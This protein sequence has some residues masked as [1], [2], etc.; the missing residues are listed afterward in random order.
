MNYSSMKSIV[1]SFILFLS[2]LT[3]A[4][5]QQLTPTSTAEECV[6]FIDNLIK[7]GDGRDEKYNYVQ[8]SSFT[9]GTLVVQQD[10]KYSKNYDIRSNIN[11]ANF[12]K[13]STSDSSLFVYIIFN[14][15]N[16]TEEEIRV[17]IKTGLIDLDMYKNELGGV[18][19]FKI[20]LSE[21][22]K[23]KDL[24]LAANRLKKIVEEKGNIFPASGSPSIKIPHIEGKPSYQETVEYINEFLE[25]GNK[26][27]LFCNT[28]RFNRR[29]AS[30][31]MNSRGATLLLSNY[32]WQGR[33]TMGSPTKTEKFRINISEVEDIRIVTGEGF[34][35]GCLQVGLWFVEKGKSAT[36]VMHLPLW[37]TAFDT[38]NSSEFKESQIYRAFNHIRQLTGA[39]EPLKFD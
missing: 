25:D 33:A 11:W 10:W 6:R 38:Y 12:K 21:K 2:C 24:E 39:P 35:G 27:D 34:A 32:S 16:I 14:D 26:N 18:L 15:K 29:S 30:L 9:G 17:D 20:P 19:Y 8:T 4:H 28:V 7:T 36:P 23:I 5:A 37:K 22:G 31:G 3:N 13:I 1:V